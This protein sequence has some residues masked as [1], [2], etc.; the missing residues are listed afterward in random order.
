MADFVVHARNRLV[1]RN[2]ERATGEL[3]W[4][5]KR[6]SLLVRAVAELP[7]QELADGLYDGYKRERDQGGPCEESEST[8]CSMR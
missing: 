5:L 2:R 3:E 6:I 7:K 4:P 1:I 8:H